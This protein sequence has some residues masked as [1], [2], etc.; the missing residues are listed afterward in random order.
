MDP[1]Q[2]ILEKLSKLDSIE[3]R[4]SKLENKPMVEKQEL[5]AET[6]SEITEEQKLSEEDIARWSKIFEQEG[7]LCARNATRSQNADSVIQQ[8]VQQIMQSNGAIVRPT[9][10]N[11]RLKSTE[12]PTQLIP[13]R[14]KIINNIVT[15]AVINKYKQ[16]IL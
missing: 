9:D 2:Q 3:E 16:Q 14:K 7:Q 12:V 10:N 1:L 11:E 4:I 6:P 15:E 8:S 5:L 13:L